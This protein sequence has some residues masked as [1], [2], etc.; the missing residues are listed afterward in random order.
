MAAVSDKLK[1]VVVLMMSNRSFDHML[2]ALKAQ[3]PRIDGLTGDES[4][5]DDTGTLVKVQPKA[6][7]QGQLNPGPDH[8][9]PGV[10]LQMFGGDTGSSRL[11]SSGGMRV[12]L[13]TSC[14]TLHATSCLYSQPW[15]L[16]SRYSIAGFRLYRVLAS[17]IALLRTMGLPL[18]K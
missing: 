15:Q 1:H 9:F 4:N 13:K 14:I 5:P 8:Q 17:V 2:G 6:A 12:I 3:D 16:S 11:P 7:F 10:D 18:A